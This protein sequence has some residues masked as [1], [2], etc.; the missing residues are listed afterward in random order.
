MPAGQDQLAARGFSSWTPALPPSSLHK[1][2]RAHQVVAPVPRIQPG[3]RA[4]GW[5][6]MAPEP[7][8]F[9]VTCPGTLRGG[10]WS[11]VHTNQ[12]KPS[13][14]L[15]PRES[16]PSAVTVDLS[17]ARGWGRGWGTGGRRCSSPHSPAGTPGQGERSARPGPPAGLQ[18]QEHTWGASLTPQQWGPT[19]LR[20]ATGVPQGLCRHH[21]HKG[22]QAG[23][24]APS[25]QGH[26]P[27]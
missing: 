18:S 21:L 8:P 17:W 14:P 26:A 15:P 11:L 13:P 27:P 1:E 6:E 12:G 23:G 4:H 9:Q 25:A 24:S 7:F 3:Q 19:V 10:T 16:P 5:T 20:E 2:G 22:R